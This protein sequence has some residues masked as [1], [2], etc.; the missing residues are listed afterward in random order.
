M[1][2][3]GAALEVSPG[4]NRIPSASPAG[5]RAENI[6]EAFTGSKGPRT[7]RQHERCAALVVDEVQHFLGRQ[8]AF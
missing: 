3:H 1:V 7:R 6:G 2:E 4:E 8:G 5:A